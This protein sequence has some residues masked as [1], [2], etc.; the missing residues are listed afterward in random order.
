MGTGKL[1]LGIETMRRAIPANTFLIP[2]R[3]SKTADIELVLTFGVHGHKELIVPV[4]E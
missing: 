1:K 4:G 3:P 2:P